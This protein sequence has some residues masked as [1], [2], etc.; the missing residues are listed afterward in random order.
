MYKNEYL[1]GKSGMQ[2]GCFS[3]KKQDKNRSADEIEK[4]SGTVPD[5]KVATGPDESIVECCFSGYTKDT[6]TFERKMGRAD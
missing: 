2:A 3:N 1:A 6:A 4:I 5:E